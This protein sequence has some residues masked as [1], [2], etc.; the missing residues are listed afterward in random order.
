[1]C[2]CLVDSILDGPEGDI[3]EGYTEGGVVSIPSDQGW[4]YS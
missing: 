4:F 1:M 3:G 2:S